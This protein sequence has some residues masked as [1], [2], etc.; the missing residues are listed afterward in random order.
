MATYLTGASTRKVGEFVKALGCDPG[1]SKW[2]VTRICA[3][4]D[5]EFAPIR[6]CPLAHMVFPYVFLDATYVRVRMNHE[7]VCRAVII[8]TSVTAGG[9]DILGVDVGDSEDAVF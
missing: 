2:T 1:L 7:V 9:S 5:R 3:D 6:E 8:A 4:F